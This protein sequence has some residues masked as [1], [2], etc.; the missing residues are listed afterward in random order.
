ME[1]E[2][3]VVSLKSAKK[4]KKLR[5]KQ[6]SL[7]WWKHHWVGNTLDRWELTFKKDAN[8]CQYEDWGINYISAFTVA[9]LG[10]MLPDIYKITLSKYKK[11]NVGLWE[12]DKQ[13]GK[14]RL[15]NNFKVNTEA[16]GR[17]E[18]LIHLLENKLIDQGVL[19]I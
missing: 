18:C 10:E 19:E 9:E 17:A 5:I 1:L 15:V 3:Q 7:F 4:L 6:D 16:N 12:L 13:W 11:I 2:K 14:E 8:E